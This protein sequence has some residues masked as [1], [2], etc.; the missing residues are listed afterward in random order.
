MT[1]AGIMHAFATT[2]CH[3]HC[4]T[5]TF[6]AHTA[7]P[8]APLHLP[9][10]PTWVPPSPGSPPH[11]TCLTYHPSTHLP[12]LPATSH[13]TP[14]HTTCLLPHLLLTH[15]CH[16]TCTHCHHCLT[17]PHTTSTP[18]PHHTCTYHTFLPLGK[19]HRRRLKNRRSL[20]GKSSRNIASLAR[21]RHLAASSL[22]HQASC[23]DKGAP[24]NARRNISSTCCRRIARA[25]NEHYLLRT[26]G[27]GAALGNQARR[28]AK[29][30]RRNRRG[31]ANLKRSKL[32][33]TK[34]S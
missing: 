4:H 31:A 19:S 26:L 30:R 3:C 29:I 10:F 33:A 6:L 8:T 21:R 28:L 25:L 34:M 17:C 14:F 1:I 18:F 2:P 23:R 32:M 20:R 13:T 12:T 7:P 16:C 11:A 24:E 9:S 27:D 15:T 5:C 22:R